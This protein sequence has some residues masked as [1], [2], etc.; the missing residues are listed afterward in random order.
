MFRDVIESKH[1]D[2]IE[3]QTI[4]LYPRNFLEN[5]VPVSVS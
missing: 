4:S 5:S 2:V 1:G 3:T